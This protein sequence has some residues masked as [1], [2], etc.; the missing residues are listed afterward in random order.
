MRYCLNCKEEFAPTETANEFCSWDCEEE[1]S[2]AEDAE[3]D[4]HEDLCIRAYNEGF[5]RNV[6]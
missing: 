1:H 4:E 6:F 5:G 2:A 3:Y